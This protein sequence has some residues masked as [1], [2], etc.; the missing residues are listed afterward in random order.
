MKAEEKYF[1]LFGKNP[2]IIMTQTYE[3][4][5]LKSLIE[6]AINSGREINEEDIDNAYQNV[7]YDV[8]DTSKSFTNFQRKK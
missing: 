8:I 3:D 7:E 4:E 2:P 5:P 6:F 1:N